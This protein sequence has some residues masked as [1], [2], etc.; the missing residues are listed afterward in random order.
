M[1]YAPGPSDIIAYCSLLRYNK[2]GNAMKNI[3]IRKTYY[4]V[5]HRY[6]TMNNV[7]MAIALL[8]GIG[9][10]WASVGAMQRNYDLQKEVDDKARHQKLLELEAQALTFEQ[11]YYQTTEYQELAVRERLNLANP[12]EKM[13]LLPP[14]SVAAT[15]TD[16]LLA[17]TPQLQP[18]E[19]QSSNFQQWVNFLFGGNYKSQR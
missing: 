3:N 9:W 11:K 15:Q 2:H 10:A 14:N 8:V 13:I 5:R 4:L 16:A 1:S 17:D 19:T 7:V 6:L 12:G 18:D